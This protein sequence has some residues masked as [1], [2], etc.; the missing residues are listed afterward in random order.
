MKIYPTP[1]KSSNFSVPE[2]SG[3]FIELSNNEL[4]STIKEIK[5]IKSERTQSNQY[6]QYSQYIAESIDKTIRYTDYLAEQCY[7]ST[8]YYDTTG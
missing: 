1:V 5:R 2:N 6:V 8:S 3:S 4:N 7:I